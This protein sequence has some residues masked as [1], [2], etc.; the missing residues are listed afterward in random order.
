MFYNNNND[1]DDLLI[2]G[3]SAMKWI[4]FALEFLT[5]THI[6]TTSLFLLYSPFLFYVIY[7]F[8]LIMSVLCNFVLLNFLQMDKKFAL[9]KWNGKLI[10]CRIDQFGSLEA[11]IQSCKRNLVDKADD[12]KARRVFWNSGFAQEGGCDSRRRTNE[13]NLQEKIVTAQSGHGTL[14]H[15]GRRNSNTFLDRSYTGSFSFLSC[16]NPARS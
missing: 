16:R 8:F 7:I 1:N 6:S 2:S 14:T 3:L 12:R 13:E 5:S 4:W 15:T 9:K 11:H 10:K